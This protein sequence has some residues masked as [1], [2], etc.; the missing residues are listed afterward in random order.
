M[1]AIICT[2]YGPPNVLKFQEVEK[3][4]PKDGQVLIR[5]HATSVSRAD[6]ELRRFDF[7]GWIALPIRL[8]F[9]VLK[10]RVRIL[11]QE[12]S[13]EVEDI[14]EG[15][16]SFAP[17]D[18][19]F[20]TTGMK[21]GAYA[22]YICLDQRSSSSVITSIPANIS[23]TDAAVIPYG[24]SEALRFLRKANIKA[25]HN[26]LI[27]GAGGSFGTYAVQLAKNFGAE[28]TAVDSFSK[29]KILQSLGADHTIDYTQGEF[30]NRMQTFD[31]I[32]DVVCKT[33]LSHL[34]RMLRHGGRCVLANPQTSHIIRGIWTI[35][36][37]SRKVI[38]SSGN[39]SV[40]HLQ[41]IKD[42]IETGKLKPV[43]DRNY[44]LEQMAEAHRY[45]E[46]EQKIGNIVIMVDNI[47]LNIKK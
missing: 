29:L 5:I 30:T 21:L 25:G 22:E 20:G 40:E 26:I 7:P 35:F 38:F 3:P 18:R 33:P 9:G 23:F 4:C 46:T 31:I 44:A 1:K 13:G 11:G 14:G 43:I 28:V 39:G 12:F 45:A 27:I 24:A 47:Q 15:V 32:F 17:G 8:W 36:S 6:C 41:Y 2:A 34:F 19:V 42:L 16:V 10:P 37:S